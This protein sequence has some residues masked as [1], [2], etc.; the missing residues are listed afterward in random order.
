MIHQE[1]IM[2]TQVSNI[3]KKSLFLLVSLVL[4][5][6]AFNPPTPDSIPSKNGKKVAVLV[7][8]SQFPTHTHF[9]TSF[10]WPFVDKLKVDWEIE[11][12]IIQTI[13]DQ[14][15]PNTEFE[16]VNLRTLGIKNSKDADFVRAKK[17]VW[18][19]HQDK[20]EQAK[21]LKE[22]DV[23][24]VINIAEQETVA[25]T[26]C[27]IERRNYCFSR[28]SKGYGLVSEPNIL[29]DIYYAS[30]SFGTQVETLNPPSN[31]TKTVKFR[32]INSRFKTNILLD[33]RDRP[34]GLKRI[35][36]AELE[37]VKQE[38]LNHFSNIG[39][40]VASYLNK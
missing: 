40:R 8:A 37:P 1:I 4:T 35:T 25:T 27:P 39:K 7:D 17:G 33:S 30:A 34:R 28:Y 14:I 10:S 26:Y 15:E 3:F 13:R 2:Q 23:N 36:E 9:G 21:L 24:L 18:A 5:G 16:V 11:E 22:Q 29:G 31:L 38:I 6:C 32:G 12:A 19:F 20:A